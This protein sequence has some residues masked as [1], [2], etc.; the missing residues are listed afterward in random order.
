MARA[1][2]VPAQVI[3]CQNK[4]CTKRGMYIQI[5][6]PVCYHMHNNYNTGD[7]EISVGMLAVL[8]KLDEHAEKRA[9]ERER[10]RMWRE[11]ERKHKKRMLMGFMQQMMSGVGVHSPFAQSHLAP[12]TTVPPLLLTLLCLL[13]MHKHPTTFSTL[14][15]ISSQNS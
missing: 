4:S 3:Q 2:V 14:I 13:L 15:I 9:E 1:Q 7:N 5:V 8:S 11:Q 6:L 12:P 10:R